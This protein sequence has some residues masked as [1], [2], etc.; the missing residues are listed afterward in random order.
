MNART[1]S[2]AVSSMGGECVASGQSSTSGLGS[3][4]RDVCGVGTVVHDAAAGE[5]GVHGHAKSSE[6][7]I[8]EAFGQRQPHRVMLGGL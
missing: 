8:G 6:L 7:S 4:F 3:R 5:G 2:S 1:S